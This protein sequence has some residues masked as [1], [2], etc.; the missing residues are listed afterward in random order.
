LIGEHPAGDRHL[1]IFGACF[2]NWLVIAVVGGAAAWFEL[3]YQLSRRQ[4]KKKVTD[5][6]PLPVVPETAHVEQAGE[7]PSISPG[8]ENDKRMNTTA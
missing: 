7:M 5:S 3:N 8:A 1:K 4:E 2:M 6:K